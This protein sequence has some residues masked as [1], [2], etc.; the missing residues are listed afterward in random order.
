MSKQSKLILSSLRLFTDSVP[1]CQCVLTDLWLIVFIRCCVMRHFSQAC[2]SGHERS[3][4]SHVDHVYLRRLVRPRGRFNPAFVLSINVITSSVSG[5][6]HAQIS[7]FLQTRARCLRIRFV[8][9]GTPVAS[10]RSP[11]N[12]PFLVVGTVLCDMLSKQGNEGQKFLEK[13]RNVQIY[14][15]STSVLWQNTTGRQG[16]KTMRRDG[17]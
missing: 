7:S 6:L 5:L 9:S 10:G 13:H 8:C 12:T 2:I 11:F 15:V 17:A 16:F 3:A 14:F 1:R 4:L